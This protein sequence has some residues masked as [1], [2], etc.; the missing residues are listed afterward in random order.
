MRAVLGAIVMVL[1]TLPVLAQGVG[2]MSV[3]TGGQTHQFAATGIWEEAHGLSEPG[4]QIEIGGEHSDGTVILLDFVAVDG[5][6]SDVLFRFREPD[7]AEFYGREWTEGPG[8]RVTVT[9]LRR[10]G[11]VVHI[12]GNFRGPILEPNIPDARARMRGSFVVELVEP[13]YS[14]S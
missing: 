5:R 4:L 12:S 9:E 2:R 1:W 13:V 3:E 14:P 8:F 11:D 6:V 10:E 7:T